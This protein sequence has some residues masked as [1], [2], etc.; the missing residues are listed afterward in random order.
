[1]P[2]EERLRDGT[3]VVLDIPTVIRNL[4]SARSPRWRFFLFFLRVASMWFCSG[5]STRH[6][7][8]SFLTQ[9][10]APLAF[11]GRKSKEGTRAGQPRRGYTSA[12]SSCRAPPRGPHFTSREDESAP[13]PR[14]TERPVS[15]QAGSVH[16]E[17]SK[18]P[19]SRPASFSSL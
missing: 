9:N 8:A 6:S 14:R 19:I 16:N 15:A 17:S 1:M 10:V 18:P 11:I 5:N 3:N 13:G 12:R 2:L 7:A 4:C